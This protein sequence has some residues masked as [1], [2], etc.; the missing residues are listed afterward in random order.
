[1][2]R[3][4][5]IATLAASQGF[6]SLGGAILC[7]HADGGFCL[8]REGTECC[9]HPE[10]PTVSDC[11]A[12]DAKS[13][14]RHDGLSRHSSCDCTHVAIEAD[15]LLAVRRVEAD[16]SHGGSGDCGLQIAD[17]GIEVQSAIRNLKST[18]DYTGAHAALSFLEP[19]R[20]RC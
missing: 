16:P 2:L 20:L 13:G 18:I 5:L 11:C 9:V 14:A 4:V 7:L 6:S 8:E 12:M 3:C 10:T 17:C 15:P 1:M 19:V